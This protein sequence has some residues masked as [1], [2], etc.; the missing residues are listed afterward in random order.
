MGARILVVEDNALNMQ[1]VRDILE[2]H[3]HSVDEATSVE[4]GALKFKMTPP[5]L[6]LLDIQIP[7]GGGESLLRRI[8]EDPAGARLPVIAVTASAMQGDKERLLAAGFDGYM[9]KP[10]DTREFSTVIARLLK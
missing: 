3:G 9:S 10:I 5:D 8:R 1:L 4:E 7:G 2:F 6:V